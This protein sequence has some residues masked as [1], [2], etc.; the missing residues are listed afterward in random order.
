MAAAE[1]RRLNAEEQKALVTLATAAAAK[2]REPIEGSN[3][4][5]EDL[6][7]GNPVRHQDDALQ[8]VARFFGATQDET[9]DKAAT[10]RRFVPPQT[11]ANLMQLTLETLVTSVMPGV[12][13]IR[14]KAR[15]PGARTLAEDQNRISEFVSDHGGLYKAMRDAV[16][17]GFISPHFGIKII[18]DKDAPVYRRIRFEAVPAEM[19]GYEPVYRRFSWHRYEKQW[20]E[21]PEAWQK[22]VTK[23]RAEKNA[24]AK[25]PEAW[26]TVTVTE[27]YHKG[28]LMGETTK[29]EKCPMSAF[30]HGCDENDPELS[31]YVGTSEIEACPL[32]IES[33]LKPG[34]RDDL[35][36]AE[37][38]SWIPPARMLILDINAINLEIQTLA[39]YKAFNKNA[40]KKEEIENALGGAPNAEVWFPI[41]TTDMA[42]G[43][44]NQ[45][46]PLEKNSSLNELLAAFNMHLR[47]WF[48]V[49]G[50]MEMDFGDAPSPRKTRGESDSIVSASTS[51]RRA[52][53]ETVAR[54]L[55]KAAQTAAYFQKAVFGERITLPDGDILMVPDAEKAAL[56]LRVD[57]IELG[58]LS[59]RQDFQNNL[60]ILQVLSNVFAKWPVAMPGL[61]KWKLQETLEMLGDHDAARFLRL[62]QIEEGPQ[63]R[64]LAWMMNG[65]RGEIM[66]K[67]DDNPRLFLGYYTGLI[68]AAHKRGNV[69]LLAALRA[70]AEA[71]KAKAATEA[72]LQS[73]QGQPADV[74]VPFSGQF[75]TEQA[76]Q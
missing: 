45:I 20:G 26:D 3:Q 46:R 4:I 14:S 42:T 76:F 12:P 62:P 33:F 66:V 69:T 38:L 64:V 52:R 73:A 65:Q 13:S 27:I 32:V 6:Y 60:T 17:D 55:T 8:T 71:Y 24:E 40:I 48:M 74:G 68:E 5:L 11:S 30:V 37:A 23:A 59:V 18:P 19:C 9:R 41:G 75:R 67:P 51:R 43:V 28:L 21:L 72:A 15:V 39:R 61:I 54:A 49:T 56:S 53:L 16:H 29:G 47:L 25:P 35:S 70:V 44:S 22:S 34:K 63:D 31:H 58:H 57:A 2:I 1:A 7:A 10:K 50:M 36:T